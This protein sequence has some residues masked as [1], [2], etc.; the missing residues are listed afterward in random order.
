[1]KNVYNLFKRCARG[2][3]VLLLSGYR[4]VLSPDHGVF[5]R[6]FPN[7]VCKYHPTCSVYTQQAVEKYGVVVGLWKGLKRIGRCNPWSDGGIDELV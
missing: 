7:G 2:L 6:F 4:V 1:M 3:V 5:A